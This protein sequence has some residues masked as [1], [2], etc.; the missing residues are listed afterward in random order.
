MFDCHK[1]IG[2][3]VGS[4]RTNFE[5]QISEKTGR[6]MSG[7]S[8]VYVSGTQFPFLEHTNRASAFEEF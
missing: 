7:N 1:T 5:S 6:R 8:W 4:S 3:T 2:W